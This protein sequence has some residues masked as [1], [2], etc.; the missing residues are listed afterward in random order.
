MTMH[1]ITRCDSVP[2]KKKGV[3]REHGRRTTKQIT[4]Q[5]QAKL[6]SK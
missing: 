6:T 3:Q 1:P 4:F 2:N 5:I